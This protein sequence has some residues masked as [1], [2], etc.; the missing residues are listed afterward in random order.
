MPDRLVNAAAVPFERL[1]L[2]TST[3][4]RVAL[5]LVGLIAVSL[6]LRETAI[7][8]RYWIDEGL[9]V[10]IA[11]HPLDDIPGLLRQDGSPPLYYLLLGVWIRVLGDGEAR[12]H[13]LSLAF[14]LMTVPLGFAAG[15]ALFS[16][17]AGWI[18]AVVAALNPFLNYY[19]QE[20]RMYALVVLLSMA[21][22]TTYALAFLHRRRGWLVGFALTGAALLYTHNWGLFVLAGSAIALAP[23]LRSRT[24]S[25]RDAV[26]GYGAIGLLYLP[27]V[28]TL[29]SQ[30]RHTGAPWSSS[31]SLADL[32]GTLATLAGGPGP[33]VALLLAGG[34]G[35][36][37]YRLARSSNPRT[38]SVEATTVRALGIMLLAALALAFVVSQISPA[39]TRALLRG[40]DRPRDR[41]GGRGPG[42]GRD[43]GPG[44]DGAA[45]G[46]VA[47]SAH[48]VCE[49]QE[50]RPSRR[51]A[52]RG[53]GQARRP[54]GLHAS[55]AGA[56]SCTSTSRPACAGPA[57]WVTSATPR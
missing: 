5:G 47:A 8:A 18:V 26:L 57:A 21:F 44:H 35:V 11:N 41:P 25:M 28:P 38:P 13:A 17:R 39:W 48:H 20:T 22:A 40:A 24:V 50:R 33:G 53:Q 54:R 43:A 3:R 31:P 14:A 29:L 55:R 46:A 27:W 51:R 45:G 56:R 6:L 15:R 9:S 52:D 7:H 2:P 36:A 34:S 23:L 19:A 30:L 10:G 4:V 1:R 16:E 49:Q 37:A 42:P 12:T 32:P